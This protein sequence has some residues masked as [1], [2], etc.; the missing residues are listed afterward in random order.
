MLKAKS[1]IHILLPLKNQNFRK[2]VS[3]HFIHKAFCEDEYTCKDV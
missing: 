2:A 1:H 3:T